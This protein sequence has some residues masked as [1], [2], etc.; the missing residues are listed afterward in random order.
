MYLKDKNPWKPEYFTGS[1]KTF[2]SLNAQNV[3]FVVLP[4]VELS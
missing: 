2:V 4:E 3:F 1:V